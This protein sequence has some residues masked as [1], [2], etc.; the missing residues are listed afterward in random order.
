[1]A[2]TVRV[3][4]PNATIKAEREKVAQRVLDYFSSQ[5]P[6]LRLLCF[7]D[8]EDS[9][10][11]KRD[12]GEANRGL[13]APL[14]RNTF[15]FDRTPWPEYVK[16]CIF[17]DDGV[18]MP[19]PRVFDHVIYLH[20]ATCADGTGLTMTLAHELQHVI[21]HNNV[22]LLWAANSLIQNLPR[23]VE[24]LKVRASEIPIERE[25]RI[26]AKRA[27]QDLCG[28]Q[29]VKEYVCRKIA[30]ALGSD[31]RADWQF[32]ADLGRSGAVDLN[33]ETQSLFERYKYYRPQL[34]E[35]LDKELK[36][37]PD[38]DFRDLCL[39]HFFEKK[40]TA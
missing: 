16:E 35:L 32:I 6:A 13:Y 26:I 31:D 20:G 30:E 7:L 33:R 38:S 34:E 18:S 36:E 1:M 39:N 23:K 5:L 11:F 3:K 8:D 17:V 19:F 29:Q 24:G 9:I 4:S 28:E 27:A 2:I 14:K 15:R 40:V 10:E 21:Q 12:F 22:P 25:A 37:N